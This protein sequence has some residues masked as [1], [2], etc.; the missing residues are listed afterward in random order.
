M[1][2]YTYVQFPAFGAGVRVASHA[3]L[4]RA[5]P[6][7]VASWYDTSSVISSPLLSSHGVVTHITVYGG[8]EQTNA[9]DSRVE[10]AYEKRVE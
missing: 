10:A 1:H 5:A 9:E 8:A 4:C 7:C 6:R 2:A 3:A